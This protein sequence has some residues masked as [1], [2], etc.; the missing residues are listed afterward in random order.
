MAWSTVHELTWREHRTGVKEMPYFLEHF[1][2]PDPSNPG[3]LYLP[4][5]RDSLITSILSAGTFVGAL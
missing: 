3:Q 1:G 5:G 2:E 4:T